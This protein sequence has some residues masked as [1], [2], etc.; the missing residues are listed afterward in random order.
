MYTNKQSLHPIRVSIRGR[1][2]QRGLDQIQPNN[3][4]NVVVYQNRATH[5]INFIEL[6]KRTLL[7]D[8][9]I[10]CIYSVEKSL[11]CAVNSSI[12]FKL[13]H[14]A[15]AFKVTMIEYCDTYLALSN[16]CNCFHVKQLSCVIMNTRQ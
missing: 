11:L 16:F 6:I 8:L 14:F 12:T 7:Y 9:G 10:T 13:I 1:C 4:E 15:S 5:L 2:Q 3:P